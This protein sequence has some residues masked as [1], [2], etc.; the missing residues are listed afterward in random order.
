M[1]LL[2]IAIMQAAAQHLSEPRAKAII[3]MLV[4]ATGAMADAKGSVH[5]RIA[6]LLV[7]CGLAEPRPR[8][9]AE[10]NRARRQMALD[11]RQGV[12]DEIYRIITRRQSRE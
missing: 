1:H 3:R 9:S 10:W 8:Y 6:R 2:T 7:R 4:T 12:P 11:R 5:G